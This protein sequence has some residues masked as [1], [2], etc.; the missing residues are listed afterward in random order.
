[1]RERC[2]AMRA[3][4]IRFCA[5]IIEQSSMGADQELLWWGQQPHVLWQDRVE[6]RRADHLRPSRRLW[7]RLTRVW[8]M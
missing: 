4:V 3:I 1:M 6:Q 8:C 7:R 2:E 5:E